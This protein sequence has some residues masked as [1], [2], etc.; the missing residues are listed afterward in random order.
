MIGHESRSEP[1]EARGHLGP[2]DSSTGTA[3]VTVVVVSHNS[4]RHLAALAAALTSSSLLPSRMLVVDNASVDDTVVQAGQAGFEVY[5]TGSNNGFGAGCNAGLRAASTEFVLFCNPD[6]RPSANALERL[7]VALTNTSTAA[8]AGAAFDH[9]PKARRFSRV[10]GNLWSFLPGWLQRRVPRLERNLPVDQSEDQVVVDYAVGA[11]ILC[12][13]AALRSVGGFDEGFFLY[14]EE[15][16]LSRRLGNCGW[17]T[18]LVPSALVDHADSTSSEGVDR[19]V[20]SPFRFHSLYWYYRRY[21]SRVYAEFARCAL[22]V[23]VVIDRAYRALTHQQQVYGPRTAIAAF[24]TTDS[25]RRDY[26]RR[27]SKGAA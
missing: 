1:D 6:A 15:E 21:H 3:G 8:I 7:L 25:V 10:T 13:V 20:M 24:R 14:S 23:C 16:D 11:F 22:S 19:A 9:S 4:A 2:S 5:E 26:E 17:Q 12:R 27:A 18:L